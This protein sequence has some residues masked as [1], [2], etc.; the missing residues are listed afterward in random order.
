[1]PRKVLSSF[2]LTLAPFWGFAQLP[3]F[4]KNVAEVQWVVSDLDRTTQRW[5]E[6]G[7][8]PIRNYG[9]VEL[10]RS[11]IRGTTTRIKV[12]LASGHLG[13]LPVLWI[14][15]VGG[16]NAYAEFLERHR[17][18]IFCL[19]HRVPS[20][21]ALNQELNRLANIGVRV[22]QSGTMK[23]E[24]VIITYA[25][26]DTEKGGKY[27][28]GLF[29]ST[30][31]SHMAS[32]NSPPVRMKISQFAFVVRDLMPVSDFWKKL[33]MPEMSITQPV[34][35]NRIY[36]GNPG[37]FDQKLGWQRHGKVVYE[38]VMP[39]RG[40]T[41]YLDFLRAH[42]EGF[43]HLAFE[44]EDLDRAIAQ[45]AALGIGTSQSGSWGEEGKPG[46]GRFA[47]LDTDSIGGVTI[48]LLWNLR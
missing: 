41:V 8:S 30:G 21:E 31:L 7:F 4:Y 18:G 16:K 14:Q 32:S 38:W 17:D 22:L 45:W 2:I 12:R 36:R 15:P 42:G 24:D 47:Y 48:E 46:S 29:H 43:H 11:S 6:L 33:G 3:D 39:L 5:S 26:L 25:Y 35:G 44:V 19:S 40:P 20:L 34:L 28:I 9:E 27:N 1:M 10:P 23:K 13:N 37:Q